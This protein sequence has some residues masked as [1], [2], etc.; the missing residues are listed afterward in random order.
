[1]ALPDRSALR[2]RL[3]WLAASFALLA[4]AG[5][6]IWLA[7]PDDPAPVPAPP[8]APPPAAPAPVTEALTREDIVQAVETALLPPLTDDGGVRP[9]S[10]PGQRFE[11]TL[12]VRCPEAL[13]AA[14]GANL[15]YTYDTVQSAVTLTA[16]PQSWQGTA[17]LAALA[18]AE[19]FEAVEGFWINPLPLAAPVCARAP[20]PPAQAAEPPEGAQAEPGKAAGAEKE[21]A[22]AESEP[23]PPPPQVALATFFEPGGSRAA[24]RRDR[25]Y[26]VTR[27]APPPTGPAPYNLVLSG[28][29]ALFEE[30][31]AIRCRTPPGEPPACLVAV[32]F[33]RVAFV[34]AATGAVLAEW[35]G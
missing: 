7:R 20:S 31:P 5:L 26:R 4:L 11:V 10:I 24:Q 28:R 8:P 13:G 33:D 23:A 16:R 22:A 34:D 32:T 1:M 3:A 29:V 19:A 18:P 9:P 6:A 21:E 35:N 12:P 27:K 25:P 14:T 17:L 15:T 30:G 2:R